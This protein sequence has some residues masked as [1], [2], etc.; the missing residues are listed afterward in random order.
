MCDRELHLNTHKVGIGYVLAAAGILGT[1][2]AL[3]TEQSDY[4]TVAFGI[5][6]FLFF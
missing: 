4:D 6:Q 5:P 2:V 3:A 1:V